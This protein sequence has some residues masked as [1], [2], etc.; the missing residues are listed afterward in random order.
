MT[1]GSSTTRKAGEAQ[2]RGTSEMGPQAVI[3]PGET[4]ARNST[5][6]RFSPAPTGFMHLGNARTAVFNYLYAR[7]TGGTFVLRIEDTDVTR[8]TDEATQ[9]I[10]SVVRW[11]GMDV[12][13]GP[14]LQSD[15]FDRHREAAAQLM[16]NGN[17]YECFCTK[18]E[19]EVRAEAM[20]AAGKAP[21]YDGAC[22]DISE[23]QRDAFR[24]DGRAATL[25]FRIPEDGRS[26]F[27]DAVRGEVSVAWS[28]ISDFVILRPDGSPVFYL[29]N[30]VDDL[31]MGI[32]HVIR[33]EDLIDSTHR[34]LAIRRALGAE[35][36]PTYAHCPLILGPGGAK[37]SKRHG[38]VSVEEYR[39]AGYLPQA[40]LNYLAF[41]GWGIAD[42]NEIMTADELATRFD[43]VNIN[44][45]GAAFDAQK[46]EWMNGEHI[47]Q[48]SVADLT[49]AVLPF[50]QVM[51]GQV[52]ATILAEA[53]ALAQSR[54]TT[55]V[56]IAEQCGFL[57]ADDDAFSIREESWE[58]LLGTEHIRELLVAVIDHC[59]T[60]DWT[61]EALDLRALL[62][63]L[64]LK[65]RKALPAIYSAI[66]GAH[67]GL[68]LFE[69]MHL[70]GR[71]RVL[72]RLSDALARLG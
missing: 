46:L 35:E 51:Y 55:L 7:H 15:R 49:A 38:A 68:P 52:D 12:D 32:T 56:Q 22:R 53:V 4:G 11:L 62:E 25:R 17:A 47:R 37:L 40:V 36:P 10:Q 33:G 69:S 20:K 72:Q 70:L 44:H 31:D 58:K 9:Q 54:A 3:A 5:R 1:Q 30:A 28:T 48:L 41:L 8:S 6:V 29:A 71:D 2:E 67:T 60:C 50:A 18:D 59:R 57:F 26:Q 34:V 21:G 39:D 42:G 27:T 64:E 61:V 45:A 16:A 63:P 14:Y 23:A 65:P 24:S 43:I 13:E 66:E 19:L